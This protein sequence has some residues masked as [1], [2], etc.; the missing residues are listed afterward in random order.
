MIE[1]YENGLQIIVLLLCLCVS[2][3]R[4]IRR[5]DRAWLLLSFFYGCWVLGDLYW[6]VFLIFFGTTPSLFSIHTVTLPVSP[7]AQSVLNLQT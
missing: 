3:G 7:N 6:E 2:V 4:S 5:R 1:S